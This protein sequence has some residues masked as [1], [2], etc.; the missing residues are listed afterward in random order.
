VAH[1]DPTSLPTD[2]LYKFV[3]LAGLAIAMGAT[4]IH[5]KQADR[6]HSRLDTAH[7][8]VARHSAKAVK[9]QAILR[10]AADLSATGKLSDE[11][12]AKRLARRAADLEDELEHDGELL[13]VTADA[14][15]TEARERGVPFYAVMGAFILGGVMM[16]RGFTLWYTRLQVPLDRATADATREQKAKADLAELELKRARAK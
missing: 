1:V 9:L 15:L 10:R 7:R 6:F 2:N 12:E 3:S 8:R 5:W 11:V 4:W 13:H 16:I 14:N